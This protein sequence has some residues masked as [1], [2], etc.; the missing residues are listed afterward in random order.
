MI[1][2]PIRIVLSIAYP[3]EKGGYNTV[4]GVQGALLSIAYPS[5]KGGYNVLH[6]GS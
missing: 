5:E 1:F 3:S 2:S 4:D 6:N